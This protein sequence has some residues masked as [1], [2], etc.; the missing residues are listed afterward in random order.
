[1]LLPFHI[2][3]GRLGFIFTFN[4]INIEKCIMHLLWLSFY[5][6]DYFFNDLKH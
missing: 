4:K 3:T 1:M 6:T 2:G 5:N